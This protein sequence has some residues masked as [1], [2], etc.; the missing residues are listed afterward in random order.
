MKCQFCGNPASVHLT[1]VIQH[2]KAELHLCEAC[3]AKHQLWTPPHQELNVPALL[4]LLLGA[5]TSRSERLTCPKCGLDYDQF[6]T[7]GRLGCPH[8]YLVFGE[9][10]DELLMRIHRKNQHVGK[11]PPCSTTHVDESVPDLHRQLR[12]AVA[13][14]RYEEAARL[15]D[16]IRHTIR[17]EA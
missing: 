15:R 14:E 1:E 17:G 9:R 3:A 10:I 4:D 8:D 6:R 2:S 16:L 13:E 7:R 11:T 12:V 5:S